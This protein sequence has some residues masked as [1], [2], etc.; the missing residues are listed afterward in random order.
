MTSLELG[1]RLVALCNQGQSET[2]V[3]ELYS[4]EV[5]SVEGEDSEQMPAHMQGL[6]K[7][8]EKNQWWANTHEV[9]SVTA[10]GPFKGLRDDQF[11]V[12][13]HLDTTPVGGERSQMTEVGLYEVADGKIVKEEFLYLLG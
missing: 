13:F 4:A 7:V 8:L 9:H 3:R 11:A 5:V 2:A 12:H 1:T 6:D 10:Q